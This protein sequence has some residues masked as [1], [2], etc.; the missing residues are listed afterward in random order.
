MREVQRLCHLSA[1]AVSGDRA[2]IVDAVEQGILPN[3]RTIVAYLIDGRHL[4]RLSD[5]QFEHAYRVA[6]GVVGMHRVH[7][8]EIA[9]CGNGYGGELGMSVPRIYLVGSYRVITDGVVCHLVFI[10]RIDPEGHFILKRTHYH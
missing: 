10:H 6:A 3:E 8:G 1:L 4:I 2:L 9:R 7:I 5:P